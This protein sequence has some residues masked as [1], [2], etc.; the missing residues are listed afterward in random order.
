MVPYSNISVNA[1]ESQ[2]HKDLALKLA[3]ESIVLLKNEN[4]TLP[5]SKKL[6]KV[7]ILGPNADDRE[8]PLAN[9]NGFPSEIITPLK[10]IK[11]KTGKRNANLLC[12]GNWILPPFL[13]LFLLLQ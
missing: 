4:Q 11:S 1:L 5:L 2:P 10:G 8:T 13:I 3:H 7:A 12:P 9:Y 6:K